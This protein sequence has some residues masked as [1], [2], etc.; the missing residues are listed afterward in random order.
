M[1]EQ[2]TI[3]EKK[4]RREG[5]GRVI[6]LSRTVYRISESDVYYVESESKDGMYYYVMFDTAKGFE[7]CSCK[8]FE[9]RNTKCKHIYG[10]E[11]AI[12]NGVVKDTYK[13]PAEAVKDNSNRVSTPNTYMEDEYSF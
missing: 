5:K 3:V 8:D 4:D 6:A 9:R 2:E 10:I 11:F 7:W 1:N 13:L 12:R